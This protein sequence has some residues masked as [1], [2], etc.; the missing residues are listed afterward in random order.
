M[1]DQQKD[2]VVVRAQILAR[3]DF[4]EALLCTHIEYDLLVFTPVVLPH[5]ILCIVEILY[6]KTPQREH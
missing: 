1:L 4:V 2:C 5:L 3:L 6:K